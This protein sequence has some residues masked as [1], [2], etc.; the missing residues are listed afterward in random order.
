VAGGTL[1]DAASRTSRAQKIQAIDFTRQTEVLLTCDKG[2]AAS[3]RTI[4]GNGGI[5]V[6]EELLPDLG[7]LVQRYRIGL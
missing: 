6:C 5:L 2:N 4:V 7:D 3:V 1:G